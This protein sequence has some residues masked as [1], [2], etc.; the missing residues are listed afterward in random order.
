[1][2]EQCEAGIMELEEAIETDNTLLI[3][4]SSR[5]AKHM[6][7]LEEMKKIL[8]LKTISF[9]DKHKIKSFM[10]Y[11]LDH[12]FYRGLEL[13]DSAVVDGKNLSDHSSL[14]ARFKKSK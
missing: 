14:F 1:M 10:G 8:S 9:K 4:A 11:P 7:K 12:I 6:R 5:S 2:I 13:M 3:V